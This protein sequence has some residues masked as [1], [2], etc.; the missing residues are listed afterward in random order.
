M[1]YIYLFLVVLAITGVA[2]MAK[3]APRYGVTAFGLSAFLFII[4]TIFGAV[5]LCWHCPVKLTANAVIFS[6]VAGLGGAF[7]VLTFNLA[8]REGHFGFSN[9]IYRSSFLI[10]V[11]YSVLFLGADLKWT[12]VLGILLI[13]TA[14]FLMSWASDSF[15]KG[16]KSEFRWFLLIITA[17][18]LSGAP[19]VG[20][21]LT[22]YYKEDLFLY[23]FLSYA[24]GTPVFIFEMLRKRSFQLMDR[25]CGRVALV[26]GGGAAVASYIGVFCT[27]KS[28]ETL[29][30]HVVFPISLS[31]P[32]IIGIL[33]S[34]WLFREK[35]RVSGWIGVILGVCGITI[36][37]IWK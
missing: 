14:I 10:P 36:L 12:T 29:S 24:M 15:S 22:S 6:A 9:A 3:L 17:F 7:A 33:L 37:A 4:G 11:A 18:L 1:G 35:I 25:S 19:R 30:P 21:T 32:I 26:W 2:L 31:G 28:L 5:V 16:K 8:I 13:L 27:L 34:L 23:L 20:Q